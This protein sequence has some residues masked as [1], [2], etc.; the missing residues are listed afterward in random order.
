ML[1]VH[2]V[3]TVREHLEAEAKSY[4][5]E[6]MFTEAGIAV[7]WHGYRHPR[8]RQLHGEFVPYLSIVDLLMN[9]GAEA[10]GI[11]TGRLVVEQGAV[12]HEAAP[13]DGAV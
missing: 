12:A 1:R 4:L 2:D 9:H 13:E 6:G 11:L 3:G 10:L 7:E 5:D 8:Y